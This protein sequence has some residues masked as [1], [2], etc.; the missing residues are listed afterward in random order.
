M[1]TDKTTTPTQPEVSQSEQT[2]PPQTT[3]PS[4]SKNMKIWVGIIGVLL[5]FVVSA[6]SYTLGQNNAKK[7]SSINDIKLETP[8]SVKTDDIIF[9][10]EDIKECPDGSFVGRV[11][12][13]CEFEECSKQIITEN[14]IYTAEDT[15]FSVHYPEDWVYSQYSG[16]TPRTSNKV[17]FRPSDLKVGNKDY[18]VIVVE[19]FISVEEKDLSTFVSSYFCNSP[20]DCL[21]IDKIT[22]RLVSGLPAIAV[23][24]PGGPVPSES[25]VFMSGDSFFVF[26]ISYNGHYENGNYLGKSEQD[27]AYKQV[28]E[29]VLSSFVKN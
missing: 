27:M 2:D 21:S 6:G 24:N 13:S 5:L 3:Q 19:E 9:C 29:E 10:T 28:F 14:L 16:D 23:E 22:P 12:P 11:G 25:V 17:S 1:E 4:Q 8:G 20:G 18:G 15:S 26:G 7:S